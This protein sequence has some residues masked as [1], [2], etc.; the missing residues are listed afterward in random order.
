MPSFDEKEFQSGLAQALDQL[1]PMMG[2]PVA[3]RDN[4]LQKGF[5][6]TAAE[7]AAL[8]MWMSM[9]GFSSNGN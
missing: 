4:F 6:E 9:M 2:M 5:S 8:A 1:E 7:Q 3:V